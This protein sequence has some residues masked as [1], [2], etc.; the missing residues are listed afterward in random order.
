MPTLPIGAEILDNVAYGYAFRDSSSEWAS[1][2]LIRLGSNALDPTAEEQPC[3]LGLVNMKWWKAFREQ[4]RE[5]A[6]FAFWDKGL[7][8]LQDYA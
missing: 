6:Y 1:H 3:I 5:N 2:D 4:L 8:I 7:K